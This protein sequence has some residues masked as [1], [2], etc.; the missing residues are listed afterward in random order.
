MPDPSHARKISLGQKLGDASA[1][2]T[3]F[4]GAVRQVHTFSPVFKVGTVL[5]LNPRREEGYWANLWEDKL[6]ERTVL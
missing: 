5:V 2:V 3:G 1:N 6:L 4:S